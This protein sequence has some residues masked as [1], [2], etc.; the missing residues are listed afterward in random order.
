[1]TNFEKLRFSMFGVQILYIYA[2]FQLPSYKLRIIL[3]IFN[4]IKYP[5]Y[6]CKYRCWLDDEKYKFI[7]VIEYVLSNRKSLP[8]INT[9]SSNMTNHTEMTKFTQNTMLTELPNSINEEDPC[10]TFGSLK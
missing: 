1:M 8:Y 7:P 2:H 5:A 9:P 10:M 4:F 3:N 6:T